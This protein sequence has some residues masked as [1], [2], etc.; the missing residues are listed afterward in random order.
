M[1]EEEDNSNNERGYSDNL[2]CSSSTKK[3]IM[4]DCIKLFL[5]D[6]PEYEGMK[7][8]QNFILKRIAK[9]YLKW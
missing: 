3:M 5:E 7:I 6:N 8:T 2:K 1:G 9:Y 4:E